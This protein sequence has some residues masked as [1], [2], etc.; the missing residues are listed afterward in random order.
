MCRAVNRVDLHRGGDI[1]AGLLETQRETAR[2]R[3]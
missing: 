3:K 2:A 1:K